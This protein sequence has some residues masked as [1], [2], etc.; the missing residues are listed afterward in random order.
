MRFSEYSCRSQVREGKC[1]SDCT[2]V[3]TEDRWGLLGIKISLLT[4]F[5]LLILL[6]YVFTI[7]Y[8]FLVT[9]WFLV[10]EKFNGLWSNN[11]SWAFFLFKNEGTRM[12]RRGADPEGYAANF[13]ES[14]QIMQSKGF[15]SSYVQVGFFTQFENN[16]FIFPF[17]FPFLFICAGTVFMSWLLR[18]GFT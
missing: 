15:T 16:L 1:N 14:E 5:L 17:R 8:Q 11:S 13:V 9:S 7:C 6:K 4:S 12:W 3:H 10:F 18:S 2:K